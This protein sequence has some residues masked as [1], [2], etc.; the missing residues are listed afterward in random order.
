MRSKYLFRGALPDCFNKYRERIRF[1]SIFGAASLGRRD[2]PPSNYLIKIN[3]RLK[4]ELIK[5]RLRARFGQINHGIIE[6]GSHAPPVPLPL[7]RDGYF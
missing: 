2:G 1:F 7:T 3:A 5:T 6:T 4:P